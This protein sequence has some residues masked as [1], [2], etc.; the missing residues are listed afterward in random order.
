MFS[1]QIRVEIDEHTMKLI[2]G[3]IAI[4]LAGVTSFF[5]E[6]PLKSISASYH[7]GGWSRDIFVG[8][9]FAI[10]AF[11]FSYNGKPPCQKFQMV[12]SKIGAFAA[13]GVA[14]LPCKCT[15]HDEIIPYGHG[16]S[17][18]VMFMVLA[19][20]CYFFFRRAWGKNNW[21]A[22]LRANIYAICG[23][24]I[25]ASIFIISTDYFLDGVI[26]S[27]ISRL[28]YYVE[29][30]ALTAFGIAWLSASQIL[31]L[32]TNKDDRVSLLAGTQKKE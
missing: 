4:F 19:V 30:T 22:M 20:F 1:S 6:T 16:I 14:M 12:I 7:E 29:A 18:A 26:S 31:P 17:T 9:L 2:V 25:V 21:H 10:S 11:L 27:S 8:C 23:I 32:I 3:L 24:V 5:S 28:T 15:S 13:I